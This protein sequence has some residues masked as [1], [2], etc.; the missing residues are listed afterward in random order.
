MTASEA[1]G[2]RGWV[3]VRGYISVVVEWNQHSGGID[4]LIP[5]IIQ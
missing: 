2:T 5:D 1:S 4:V 3:S